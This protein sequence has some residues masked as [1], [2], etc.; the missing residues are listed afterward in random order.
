AGDQP[1]P[2][3]EA[4]VRRREGLRADLAD[5]CDQQ[6]PDRASVA[7]GEK[8]EGA[9]GPG[10]G[11]PRAVELRIRRRRQRAAHPMEMLKA[12]TG[13]DIVHVAY[14]GLTPA[15]NE[16]VAGQVPMMVPGVVT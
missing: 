4:A 15:F 1:R 5:R 2:V 14:K 12:A 7:A 6:L 16:V 13:I 11:A 8:R 3:P 9:G 10:E